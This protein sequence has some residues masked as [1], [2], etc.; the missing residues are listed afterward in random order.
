LRRLGFADRITATV[1]ATDCVPA[2]GQ[3]IVAVEIRE[4]DAQTRRA[5]E[6]IDDPAAHY[7]LTAERAVV[8]GLGGGCQTPVG[9]FATLSD[10]GEI[11]LIAIVAALD[12]SRIIRATGRERQSR[13]AALGAQI[14][15]DLLEQGAGE[16]LAEARVN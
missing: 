13:A 15:N 10:R 7:A 1:P 14:A 9:A 12:G 2:P 3:G 6:A 5:V 4:D 8:T 11:D 16:I